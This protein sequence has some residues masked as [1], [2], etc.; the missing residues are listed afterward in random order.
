MNRAYRKEWNCLTSALGDPRVSRDE[1]LAAL[2]EMISGL[3][4]RRERCAEER[5]STDRRTS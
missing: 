1:Y 5:P 4:E 3:R 2:D